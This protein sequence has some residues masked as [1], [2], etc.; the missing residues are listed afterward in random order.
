MDTHTTT[1]LIL[2]TYDLYKTFYAYLLLFP[3]K[4]K[5]TLGARCDVYL[6][7]LLEL[8]IAASN[9]TKDRKLPLIQ[10]ANIKL[11]TIK[12]LIR[13]AKDVKAIDEKKYIILQSNVQEIGR[14]LGGWQRTL[15][16]TL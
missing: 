15:S 3:K 16:T 2:K 5:H 7:N 13:L 8:L 12:I 10:Q 14:M 6:L 1:P 11:D 4:D 9:T